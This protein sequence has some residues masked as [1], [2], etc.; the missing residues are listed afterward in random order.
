MTWCCR[1]WWRR[2]AEAALRHGKA[3]QRVLIDLEGHGRESSF[4]GVDL[5]RTVG[6]FTSQY[7][8]MPGAGSEEA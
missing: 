2:P 5:T 3:Q 7:G 4:E 6:W 1:C 8:W